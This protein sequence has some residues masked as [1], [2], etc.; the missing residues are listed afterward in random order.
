MRPVLAQAD[1]DGLLCYLETANPRNL[2]LY[3]RHGFQVVAEVDLPKGGP[4][5][6]T[7]KREP[8]G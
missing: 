5:I 2:P 6:W 4:C 7:M 1:A 3:Q 8:I